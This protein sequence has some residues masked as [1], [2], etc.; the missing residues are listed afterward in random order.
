MC[1][2]LAA[3]IAAS[4]Q[5]ASAQ[6]EDQ[7]IAAEKARIAEQARI[8]QAAIQA[9]ADMEQSQ[10]ALRDFLNDQGTRRRNQPG[11]VAELDARF[12]EFRM[13]IPKF[14]TATVEFSW[15]LSMESKLDKPLKNIEAQTDVLLRYFITAKFKH[16]RPDALEFKDFS[17][18]ELAWETLNSAERI[19]SYL[20]L[21]VAIE[22]QEFAAPKMLEFMYKLDGE[23]L[24]LKWL[25]SHSK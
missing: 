15:A 2:I 13:A 17:R 25:T 8:D 6:T 12:L 24:R 19:G 4:P 10:A 3:F 1:A 16:P 21:A 14:R 5:Y 22:R 18:A 9:Q 20:D 23:L 7:A 11:A